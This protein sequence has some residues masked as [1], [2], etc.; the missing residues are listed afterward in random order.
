MRIWV[1]ICGITEVSAALLCGELGVDA[2]GFVLVDSPRRISPARAARISAELSAG[3]TKVGVFRR[4]HPHQIARV[5]D[6]FRP[7]LIQMDHAHR[8]ETDGSGVLTV[9]RESESVEEEVR[10]FVSA[11]PGAPFLYEGSRSGAG[12]KVDWNL[13][14]RLARLGP[15]VLAGGL[16][17]DNVAEAIH[18]VAP[19]GVDVSSGVESNPG[20]K[21]PARIGAFVEAVRSAEQETT[22]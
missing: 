13:A 4:A 18:T 16:D 9:F 7:D 22:S 19:F 8:P 21:D 15:M 17:P 2:V 11:S 10:R 6:H 5:R 3:V 12:Q 14:R 20:R 1:K